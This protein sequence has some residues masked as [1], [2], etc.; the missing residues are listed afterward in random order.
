[1]ANEIIEKIKSEIAKDVKYSTKE[2]EDTIFKVCDDRNIKDYL[3]ARKYF[4][5]IRF[6]IHIS[7]D[8]IEEIIDLS[9]ST[10]FYYELDELL[11]THLNIYSYYKFLGLYSRENEDLN[12]YNI[13][14]PL[15]FL[16]Y[17]YMNESNEKIKYNPSIFLQNLKYKTSQ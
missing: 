5:I 6:E 2:F 1:M 14:L 9:L 16:D 8:D 10:D 13:N 4:D 15:F 17:K 3:L 11:F 7:I 12:Y